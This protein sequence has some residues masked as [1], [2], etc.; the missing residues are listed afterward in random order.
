MKPFDAAQRVWMVKPAAFA[1]NPETASSNAFQSNLSVN[2]DLS[3]IA[4]AEFDD[5]VDLLIQNGVEVNV[6]ADSPEP[7]KPDAV[8]PNNWFAC[9]PNGPLVLFPMQANNR[10]KERTPE[11]IDGLIKLFPDRE[12]LDL[13]QY[14]NRGLFLEG[15]GSIVFDHG[16]SVAYANVSPRTHEEP[17]LELCS[18]IGYKP[19][20]FSAADP[21]GQLYYHANVLMFMIPG[22]VAIGL[23][24]IAQ[25]DRK[26]LQEAFE[27]SG[28]EVLRLEP[29]QLDKFAG[30][31]LCLKNTRGENLIFMSET[32]RQSLKQEQVA[33]L[34]KKSKLMVARIPIIEQTGGGSVRCMI[35]EL[36]P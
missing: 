3:E 1:F 2:I 7:A 18:K 25:S 30:N 31:M 26:K 12:I 21:R 5:L 32:A 28:L 33:F 11:A 29:L 17:F 35:A 13:T 36:F 4:R 19:I 34:E 24:S 16:A 27:T 6:W 20:F 22:G 14:E 9:I 15:T 10:R 23:E 8:F